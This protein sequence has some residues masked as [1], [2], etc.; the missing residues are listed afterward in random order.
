MGGKGK[1]GNP[2]FWRTFGALASL[3]LAFSLVV[4]FYLWESGNLKMPTPASPTP[5]DS[6][7]TTPTPKPGTNLL[8]REDLMPN[9][10]SFYTQ[11]DGVLTD[12][13]GGD[14]WLRDYRGQPLALLYW[15]SWCPDCQAMMG[16]AES[17]AAAVQEAGGRFAMVVRTGVEGETI[18]TASAYLA[19]NGIDLSTLADDN[20]ALYTAIGLHWVPTLLFFDADGVLMRA[21]NEEITA[22]SAYAGVEYAMNGGEAATAAFVRDMLTREDGSVAS[23]F[24][25]VA[26]TTVSLGENVLSESQGMLMLYAAN[27][28]DQALF[29]SVYGYLAPYS[30]GGLT[31]WL[32]YAGDPADVNATLDDLRILEAL[33]VAQERWGG[34]EDEIDLRSG[35]LYKGTVKNGNLLDYC[36]VPEGWTTCPTL[37]LCYADIATMEKLAAWEEGWLDVAANA[38]AILEGGV[39]GDDFPLYQVRYNYD[40]QGYTGEDLKMSEA[41]VTVYNAARSGV[42]PQAT[43][44]RLLDWLREAPIYAIYTPQGSVV[45]GY[46]FE[47][48]ATYA[49]LVVTAVELGD[50]EMARLAL[51][52][53]E[54]KRY[55][56]KE[57]ALNGSYIGGPDEGSYTF[58]TMYSLLA[59]QALGEEGF[60]WK[61]K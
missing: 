37:T 50:A 3:A 7:P 44:E 12:E 33:L 13:Q 18:Q 32:I 2:H 43:R 47:S 16:E 30:T 4:V 25:S 42:L 46:G 38:R 52:R 5:T 20:S 17:I 31:P 55:F 14:V 53:M 8:M 15:A 51:Y 39:L 24:A 22:D 27:A 23:E 61:R 11:W 19:D 56:A 58:D 10:R 49:A 40:E 9:I 36:A 57:G 54:G 29:D 45:E 6:A 59:W 1:K 48:T 35:A 41:M 60:V 28:G 21:Q 34:Y 26:G